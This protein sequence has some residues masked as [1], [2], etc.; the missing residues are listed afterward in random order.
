MLLSLLILFIVL[1]FPMMLS[2]SSDRLVPWRGMEPQ[3]MDETERTAETVVRTIRVT[4]SLDEDELALLQQW[5]KEFTRRYPAIHIAVDNLPYEGAYATLKRRAVLGDAPDIMLLDSNW[6]VDFAALGYLKNVD[7][8]FAGEMSSDVPAGLVQPLRWNG[9]LWGVPKDADPLVVV[10]SRVQLQ[11]LGVEEPPRSWNE[12]AA[13]SSQ[14]G[15]EPQLSSPSILAGFES[16]QLPAFLVWMAAVGG[17]GDPYRLPSLMKQPQ[18]AEQF[19]MLDKLRGQDRLLAVSGRT[20]LLDALEQGRLWSAVLPL[21]QVFGKLQTAGGQLLVQQEPS[22]VPL[23]SGGRS[24]SLSSRT[25]Y[26][27]EA[28]LWIEFVTDPLRQQ[29]FFGQTGKLPARKAAYDGLVA[30]KL[31][32]TMLAGLEIVPGTRRDAYWNQRLAKDSRL[33]ERWLSGEIPVQAL[34]AESALE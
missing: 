2:G 10:W 16:K 20:Q 3:Q 31:A 12:L 33:W 18:A 25:E 11:K 24:F 23:W 1:G 26:A 22:G 32:A 13:L 14:S 28:K 19:A 15:S 4:V 34:F 5:N 9:Y 17:A 29:S 6:V 21:S 7:S 8:L 27:G 30:D